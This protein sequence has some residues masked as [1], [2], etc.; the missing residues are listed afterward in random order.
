MAEETTKKNAP[1][2]L[3]GFFSWVRPALTT[4]R[5]LKTW[6]RCCVALAAVLILM[7]DDKTLSSMGQAGFFAA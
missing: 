5:T 6:T 4:R 1:S 2:A 3:P 7:V